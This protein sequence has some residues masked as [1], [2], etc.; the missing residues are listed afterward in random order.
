MHDGYNKYH[1]GY[2]DH[3]IGICKA[4]WRLG[5]PKGF[6]IAKKRLQDLIEEN[7]KHEVDEW[8]MTEETEMLMRMKKCLVYSDELYQEIENLL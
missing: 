7:I 2:R 8:I 6:E 4:L 1:G 5:D 3:V